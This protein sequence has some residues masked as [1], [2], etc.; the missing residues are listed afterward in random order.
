MGSDEDVDRR[1]EV[2]NPPTLL[3]RLP[4]V[5]AWRAELRDGIEKG[6]CSTDLGHHLLSLMCK[7]DTPLGE[8]IR[9]YSHPTQPH[10]GAEPTNEWR[11]D[12]LPIHPAS[13]KIGENGLTKRNY[14]WVLGTVCV[15][16]FNYCCG[17]TRPIC[18]PIPRVV[19]ANQ[20]KA[21]KSLAWTVDRNILSTEMIPKAKALKESLNSKRFD[22]SGNPVEHM[23][24]LDASKVIATWPRPGSAAVKDITELLS[25]EILGKL[26][27]PKSWWLPLDKRPVKRT[28]SR[29]RADEETWFQICKAAHLRGMMRPVRDEDLYKDVDGH[30]VVNGAGG[31]IKRKVVDGKEV[32][33]QRFISILVPTNEHSLELPG[34]Q[35]SLPYVGQ[36]T[37]IV[38]DETSDLYMYS[39]DFTSAFN[40]FRVPESWSVHFAFAKKVN[41]PLGG[42]MM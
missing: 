22:Y 26:G 38:L 21:I 7:M 10:P 39:E 3:E 28:R 17:W 41:L 1:A 23:Q 37:G 40:L 35:D 30:Y 25:D 4:E 29:V 32:E 13:L 9:S 5:G 16:N 11:G 34:E 20:Q 31:V 14:H 33:L 6:L 36:L 27:D 24:E 2:Q 8:F 19:S 12:L 15:L 42:L 18:V